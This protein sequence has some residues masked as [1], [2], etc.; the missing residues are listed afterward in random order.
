MAHI[1]IPNFS[2]TVI[3][4]PL[5]LYLIPIPRLQIGVGLLGIM[6]LIYV[7]KRMRILPLKFTPYLT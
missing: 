7:I 6:S 2:V 3:F 4:K 1:F 5:G